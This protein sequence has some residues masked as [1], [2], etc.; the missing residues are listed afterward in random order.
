MAKTTIN[1]Y[2]G[3]GGPE[4]VT[5]INLGQNGTG[6]SP[7]SGIVKLTQFINLTAFEGGSNGIQSVIGLKDLNS[8]N[9][10]SI[11]GDN[12]LNNHLSSLPNNLETFDVRG[13]NIT[14]GNISNLP[15]DLGTYNNLG[16][17]ITTGNIVNLP[18]NLI[19]YRNLGNNTTSGNLR[20][21]PGSLV[22]YDNG[23]SNTVTG[24]LST[25]PSGITYFRSI[26]NN[27]INSYY[28]GTAGNGYG[29]R[30][31]ASNM[32]YI[33]ITPTLSSGQPRIPASHLVTLLVDLTS[34]TW[35]GEKI[36]KIDGL[37]NPIINLTTYPDARTAINT[38]TSAPLNINVQINVLP[39][40]NIGIQTTDINQTFSVNIVL[41]TSPN[42]TVD[43]GDG[44]VETF[45]TTGVKTKT[46]A[47]AG[48]YTVKIYGSFASGGD[49]RPGSTT[50]ERARV[51]STSVIPTI[52][53]LT[54]FSNTFRECTSLTSIPAGLFDNNTAVTNFNS[55]FFDCTS[56][57]TI[58]AGLFDNNTAATSFNGT[59][60]NC[61]S[62][63]TIPAGLFDNNTAVTSFGQIIVGQGGVFQECTSLTTI[64][65]GLFDNNTAA[66]S[67]AAIFRNCASLTSIPAGLFD[68]NTAVTNFNGTFFDC[69]SLTTIPAGLFDNNTAA[70]SFNDTF[71][72]CTSLTTIPAGLFDNNIAVISFNDVFSG[73]TLTT[74]SYSNLLINMASNAA[75][76]LNNVPF[77]G[78]GS[79]Y[80]S[81]GETARNTFIAKSWTF[82]DGG[83]E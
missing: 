56:L 9:R 10:F 64:P 52:P 72:N 79:K 65:A 81:A 31:W 25:I 17:N 22:F 70:T 37:N 76:R 68:N 46:Y 5:S 6:S 58:P 50:A 29:K 47:S 13:Q 38:L 35:A 39:T 59:F 75:S 27:T 49:I 82:T 11:F 80:N 51:Q 3:N 83:L 14:R 28:D 20:D 43:W 61:T 26:G 48:S 60:F 40:W 7:L 33:E 53:G 73:V 77:H 57:T 69:T 66:T 63:T 4:D 16:N 67:F 1:L 19:T 41:G 32:R 8:L 62:L 18:N 24:S 74:A 42:I 30:V 45:T 21:L 54:S 55:T 34:T 2:Y 36:I 44:T 23:G 78:G 15:N 71:F 12:T